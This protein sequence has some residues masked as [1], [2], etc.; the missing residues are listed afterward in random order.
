V[1]TIFT[2]IFFTIIAFAASQFGGR[3]GWWTMFGGTLMCSLLFYLAANTFAWIQSAGYPPP[4][5]Y[6]QTMA[7]W[8]QAQTVGLPGYPPS[9]TF[10]RNALIGD[11]IWCV[12][13]TPLFYSKGLA[14][15][16][17]AR[18]ASLVPQSGV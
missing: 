3:A 18:G 11:A 8:W 17:P 16:D 10:L 13:A 12:L 2:V 1:Y 5:A 4:M 15:Q 6:P 7:G 9:W 14:A